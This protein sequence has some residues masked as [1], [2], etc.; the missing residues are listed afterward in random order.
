MLKDKTVVVG[1]TGGIAAYRICELVRLLV[2]QGAAVHVVMTRSATRFVTPMTFQALSGNPVST[3][4]FDL[5]QEHAIGHI[6][7]ARLADIVVVAPA[8]ANF[9]AKAAA[10]I[11]DDLLTTMILAT[12]CP[13]LVAPSMNSTMYLH[14][15]TQDN[16]ERLIGFSRHVVI[17]PDEGSLACGEH[18]PGRLPPPERLLEEVEVA[19]HPSPLDG[20]TVLVTAG[21]TW[22][23]LDPVRFLSNRSSGKMGYLVARKARAMGAR[24]ILVSG[25]VRVEPPAGVRLVQV[26]T[27]AEMRTAVKDAA[28]G[29]DAVVKVAAVADYR[30]S[31]VLAGKLKKGPSASA[32]KLVIELVR[33]TDILAEL[34]SLRTGPRPLLV[35]FAA[36]TGDLLSEGRRKLEKK[37]VD[38]LVVNRVGIAGVGFGADEQEALL[39]TTTGEPIELGRVSKLSLATRVLSWVAQQLGCQGEGGDDG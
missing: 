1:V 26:E 10:G 30:P 33:T 19:L 37:P 4:L 39:L 9:L 36:E 20:R 15:A 13:V 35:G 8:T 27:A 2:K 32:E 3:D 5:G 12:R 11:A 18:G 7:L 21:P 17:E 38:L 14:Q 31:K 24:V 25:P 29:V 28:A 23:P 16:L 34:C 22:E 6:D